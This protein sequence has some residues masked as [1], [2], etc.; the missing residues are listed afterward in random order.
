MNSNKG[1]NKRRGVRWQRRSVTQARNGCRTQNESSP[2]SHFRFVEKRKSY[3]EIC[4]GTRVRMV[5]VCCLNSNIWV[6]LLQKAHKKSIQFQSKANMQSCSAC[7]RFK[8]LH[9]EEREKKRRSEQLCNVKS[10]F[11]MPSRGKGINIGAVH[12]NEI[13]NQRNK[14][15][16]MISNQIGNICDFNSQNWR[17]CVHLLFLDNECEIWTCALKLLNLRRG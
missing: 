10:Y 13:S 2:R 4:N 7:F 1:E 9:Q 11:R 8:V 16:K 3:K 14:K 6:E 17:F 15:H 5:K 12:E